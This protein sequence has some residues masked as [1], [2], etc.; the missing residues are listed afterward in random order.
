MSSVE[1][2][3]PSAHNRMNRSPI[4][5]DIHQPQRLESTYDS[6]GYHEQRSPAQ[7]YV[8]HEEEYEMNPKT[9]SSIISDSAIRK[10]S[11]TANRLVE[12]LETEPDLKESQ[13]RAT[14]KPLTRQED[15]EASF[16][17]KTQ[18]YNRDQGFTSKPQ[19]I[20]KTLQAVEIPLRPD[21]GEDVHRDFYERPRQRNENKENLMTPTGQIKVDYE[22]I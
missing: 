13:Y 12:I 3:S 6:R 17:H 18:P 1:R 11:K 22:V 5:V 14:R 19:G 8:N 16:S 10:I 7:R 20:C 4:R 2:R 21:R 15:N 9:A